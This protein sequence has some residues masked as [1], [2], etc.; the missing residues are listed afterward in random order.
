[1][2]AEALDLVRLRKATEAVIATRSLDLGM[3]RTCAVLDAQIEF[4]KCFSDIPTAIIALLDI[5]DEKTAAL[6]PFA[7]IANLRELERDVASDYF[8][9]YMSLRNGNVQQA[10][11]REGCP[12]VRDFRRMINYFRNLFSSYGAKACR[13][14]DFLAD[15]QSYSGAQIGQGLPMGSGFLYPTLSRMEQE[16]LIESAWEKTS[17]STASTNAGTEVRVRRRLYRA[18]VTRMEKGL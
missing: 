7:K 15:G 9:L 2:K 3:D 10:V 1:M 16:G 17:T 4:Q 12:Y 8:P 13:I 5:I 14:L 11:I 18:R 6:E